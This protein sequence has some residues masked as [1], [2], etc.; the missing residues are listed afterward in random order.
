MT[1]RRKGEPESIPAQTEPMEVDKADPAELLERLADLG[2]MVP[3]KLKKI[4][5]KRETIGRLIIL[6]VDEEPPL[7]VQRRFIREFAE[8]LAWGIEAVRKAFIKAGVVLVVPED[9]QQEAA[10]RFKGVELFPTGNAVEDTNRSLLIHKITGG[11]LPPQEDPIEHGLLAF[12]AEEVAAM[13]HCLRTGEPRLDK[14]VTVSGP[15]LER[16]VTV[17]VRLGTPVGDILKRL[18]IQVK[19]GDRVVFGGPL[20]GVAQPDLEMSVIEDVDG[21]LVIPREKVVPLVEAPCLNCGRCVAVCPVHIPVNL[22]GR[23]AQFGFFD[24]S[25][26]LGATCCVECG[27]CAYVCPSHRPLIQYLRFAKHEHEKAERERVAEEEQEG[28]ETE[29][30]QEEA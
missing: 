25:L 22:A 20:M 24:R 30:Q 5:E 2:C 27:L 11:F 21:V 19:S 26:N 4:R 15:G 1:I 9:M 28:V 6:A 10:Q 16:P 8:E 12:A 23:F 17:K 7:A 14:L 18:D 13:G 3:W 29:E